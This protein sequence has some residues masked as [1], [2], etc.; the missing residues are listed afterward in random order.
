MAFARPGDMS[1]LRHVKIGALKG[2]YIFK[3]FHAYY[4]LSSFLRMSTALFVSLLGVF[5]RCLEF[6]LNYVDTTISQ[7]RKELLF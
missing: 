5:V 2:S 1:T 6:T 4:I 7:Q 3:V